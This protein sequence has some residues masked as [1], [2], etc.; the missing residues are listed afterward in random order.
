MQN[1]QLKY[2]IGKNSNIDRTNAFLHKVAMLDQLSYISDSIFDSIWLKC[3]LLFQ[4]NT[5]Q[6]INKNIFMA[7]K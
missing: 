1:A 5:V 6:Y 4:S 2:Q 7:F 3:I